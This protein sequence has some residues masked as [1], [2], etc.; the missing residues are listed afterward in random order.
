MVDD[1]NTSGLDFYAQV[2]EAIRDR[3]VP[4]VSFSRTLYREGGINLTKREYLRITRGNVA[5]DVCAAP[6]GNSFF[7][8]WWLSRSGP[9]H[10]FLYIIG[11]FAIMLVVPSLVSYPFSESCSY[12]LILPA[13]TFA[14]FALLCALAQHGVFGPEDLLVEVPI[15]GWIYTKLFNPNTFYALDTALMFRES[16]RRAVNAVIADLLSAQGLKALS[17]EEWKPTLRDLAR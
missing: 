2:E 16:V 9:R 7:F 5:F 10:P 11:F 12:L 15:I 14:T 17:D 4:D 6:Y 13:T 3:D 1:F 8:S